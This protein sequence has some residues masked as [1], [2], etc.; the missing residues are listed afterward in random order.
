[1]EK[2]KIDGGVVWILTR[3]KIKIRFIILKVVSLKKSVFVLKHD[4]KSL[5][6][7]LN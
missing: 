3:L 2:S 7:K 4:K 5:I 6:S 1:M